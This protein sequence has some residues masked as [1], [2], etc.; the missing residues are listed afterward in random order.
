MGLLDWLCG[1]LDRVEIADDRVWLTKQA[2]YDGIQ[3]EIGEAVA[4]RAGPTAIIVV[5]HFADCLEQ[6][7]SALAD[8]DPD[9]VLVTPADALASRRPAVDESCNILIIVSERHPSLSHDEQV[10]DFARSLPCRCRMV[11]HVSLEDP[12]LKRFSGPWVKNV[13]QRLGMKEGDAIESRLV[14][15]RIQ[16][17]LKKIAM[18][19]TGDAPTGSAEEWL[20]RNCPRQ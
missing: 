5:A 16:S 10:V 4:D 18:S 12:V 17:E 9:L 13:L 3:R 7:R 1:K 20:Q 2:K 15:R 6:L 11:R 19:A 8:F 14:N